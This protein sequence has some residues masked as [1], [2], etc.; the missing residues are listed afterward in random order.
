MPERSATEWLT[1]RHKATEKRD[2]GS[3]P[4]CSASLILRNQGEGALDPVDGV[5]QRNRFARILPVR[6]GPAREL[7]PL[8]PG[9]GEPLR[10]RVGFHA[11]SQRPSASSVFALISCVE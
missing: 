3:P 6:L 7:L 9:S 4:A 10:G 8:I 1:Q 5:V 2:G 11:A